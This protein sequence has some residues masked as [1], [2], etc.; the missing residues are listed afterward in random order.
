[1]TKVHKDQIESNRPDLTG[2][3]TPDPVIEI[4]RSKF[5]LQPRDAQELEAVGKCEGKYDKKVEVL[6]NILLRKDDSAFDILV[7]ALLET[8]QLHVAGLLTP[9]LKRKAPNDGNSEEDN[10]RVGVI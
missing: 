6:L 8:K 10:A 5:V 1:M 3:M 7:K 9:S 2:N 4:L